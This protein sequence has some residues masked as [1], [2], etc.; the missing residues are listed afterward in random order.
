[1]ALVRH[2]YTHDT[3]HGD[4]TVFSLA[5]DVLTDNIFILQSTTQD[6]ANGLD[7]NEIQESLSEFLGKTGLPQSELLGLI[8]TL[9]VED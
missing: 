4:R 1:M 5:R 7:Y 9:V 3:G 8:G 2:F 6:G